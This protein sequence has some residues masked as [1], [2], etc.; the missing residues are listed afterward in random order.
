VAARSKTSVALATVPRARRILREG[1][2]G[3]EQQA[4]ADS[5]DRIVQL[6]AR[7]TISAMAM[8]SAGDEDRDGDVA[9]V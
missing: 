2:G 3:R 6:I 4:T 1:A 5:S 8:N 9:R 7:P